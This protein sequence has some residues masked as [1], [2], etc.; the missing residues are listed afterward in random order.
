M[1][2]KKLKRILLISA[3]VITAYAGTSHF[4]INEIF[5]GPPCNGCSD[6]SNQ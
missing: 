6:D 1:S 4:T 3:V 2:V 5:A